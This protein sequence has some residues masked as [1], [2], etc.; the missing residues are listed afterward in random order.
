MIKNRHL[1]LAIALCGF[2]SAVACVLLVFGERS[3]SMAQAKTANELRET[4]NDLQ[5]QGEASRADSV[6]LTDLE[7][8]HAA[9]T[10]RVETLAMNLA[11]AQ[12]ELRDCQKILA[13]LQNKKWLAQEGDAPPWDKQIEAVTNRLRV[14][15]ESLKKLAEPPKKPCGTPP[16]D[17]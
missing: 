16:A 15:E 14:A 4:R 17:K 5:S 8:K 7:S 10:I 2:G 6:R 9:L 13:S 11:V 3:N 1:L 12:S